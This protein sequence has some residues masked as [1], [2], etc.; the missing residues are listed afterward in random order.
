MLTKESKD[1]HGLSSHKEVDAHKVG[2]PPE[3]LTNPWPEH[4]RQRS[5]HFQWK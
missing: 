4:V 5:V 1:D 2:N 3:P